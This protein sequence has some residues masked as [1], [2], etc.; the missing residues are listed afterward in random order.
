MKVEDIKPIIKGNASLL[1]IKSGGIATYELHSIDDKIY[2][3]DIDLS[4]KKDCGETAIFE[5]YYEKAI[6]LMRWIRR[7]NENGEL[8]TIDEL[9]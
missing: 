9:D 8:K 4:D 1:H 7:A 2:Y 5:R 3:V 6:T